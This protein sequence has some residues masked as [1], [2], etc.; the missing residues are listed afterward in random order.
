MNASFIASSTDGTGTDEEQGQNLTVATGWTSF[1]NYDTTK[2]R[3]SDEKI[4]YIAQ[5]QFWQSDGSL[6]VQPFRSYFIYNGGS[7]ISNRLEI[8]NDEPTVIEN[9]DSSPQSIGN[10]V[11]YNLSGQHVSHPTR[12]IYITN[13]K[14][15]Y[16]Q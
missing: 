1:G 15:I 5:D 13:G 3:N 2:M 7:I 8:A 16:I 10:N 14:K 9:V 11:F 6:E 12:G 4:Y